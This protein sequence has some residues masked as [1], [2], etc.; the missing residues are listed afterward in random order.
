MTWLVFTLGL[1]LGSFATFSGCMW[2]ACRAMH[3][4]DELS[5]LE[6]F[7]MVAERAARR[8]EGIE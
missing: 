2:W 6:R 7:A 1:A 5:E 4:H 8:A 3:P